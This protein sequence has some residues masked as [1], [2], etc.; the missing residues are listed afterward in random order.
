MKTL[1]EVRNGWM[2]ES[3]VRTYVWVDSEKDAEAFAVQAFEIECDN[4]G[5][6]G[7]ERVAYCLVRDVLSLFRETDAAFATTP[8]DYGWDEKI[9]SF[10]PE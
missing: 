3:H 4:V 9:V 8:S 1:Y 5:R 10:K 2:G 6:V 7:T